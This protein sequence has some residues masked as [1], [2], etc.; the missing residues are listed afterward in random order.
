MDMKIVPERIMMG[1]I[2][3]TRVRQHNNNR[4]LLQIFYF[5]GSHLPYFQE[6]G[7]IA[8][9]QLPWMWEA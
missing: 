9:F 2:F 5:Y 1:D 6:L 4:S 3:F 7:F 8:F